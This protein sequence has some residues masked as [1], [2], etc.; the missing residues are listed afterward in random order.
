MFSSVPILSKRLDCRENLFRM[1]SLINKRWEARAWML[2]F[3]IWQK[4]LTLC[5]LNWYW[6]VFLC[7]SSTGR[8]RYW[9]Y[10]SKFYVVHVW[11]RIVRKC[12]RLWRNHCNRASQWT[13]SI[14]CSPNSFVYTWFT[15][16]HKN[17]YISNNLKITNLYN[18]YYM[19]QITTD[20]FINYK[21]CTYT[22]CNYYV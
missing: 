6:T 7:W 17:I 15:W 1:K 3:W 18:L 9:R 5:G 11:P 20:D 12:Q 21:S 16:D 4:H 10:Q 8:L 14:T 22:I 13:C 2:V 19:H